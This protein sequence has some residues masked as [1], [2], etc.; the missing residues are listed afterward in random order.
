MKTISMEYSEYK[1]ELSQEHVKGYEKAFK[2]FCKFLLTTDTQ[3]ADIYLDAID[4]YCSAEEL[5]EYESDIR[6]WFNNRTK[7]K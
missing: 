2:D 4:E 7:G 1:E 3:N 6:E 5:Y